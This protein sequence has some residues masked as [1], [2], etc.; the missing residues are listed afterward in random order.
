[1][2][3]PMMA[4]LLNGIAQIE[5]DR[6]KPLPAY[7]GAYLD[8]M[9]R[10]MDEGIEIDGQLIPKPDLG[11][12]SQFVAANLVH[13]IKTDNEAVAAAMS[14]YLAVRMTDLKQVR[15]KEENEDISIELVF[16]E[17]YVRQYPITFG[18]PDQL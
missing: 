6:T 2:S 5:Y 11:Q 8:K 13:A 17:D 9:D 12:R 14:T 4:V 10:K 18:R 15:I 16:D 7:Q 3:N 1:M